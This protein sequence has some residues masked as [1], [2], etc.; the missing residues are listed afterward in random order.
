MVVLALLLLS[1]SYL[2][3]GFSPFFGAYRY[4]VFDPAEHFNVSYDIVQYV[5]AGLFL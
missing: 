2:L 3:I 4:Y 1:A 5:M